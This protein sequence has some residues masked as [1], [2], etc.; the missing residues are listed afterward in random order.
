[1]TV[2]KVVCTERAKTN[3]LAF[4]TPIKRMFGKRSLWLNRAQQKEHLV[5]PGI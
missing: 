2:F 1:M 5:F 4:M 3:G